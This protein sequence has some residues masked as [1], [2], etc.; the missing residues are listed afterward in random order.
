MWNSVVCGGRRG[1]KV[2]NDDAKTTGSRVTGSHP[3]QRISPWFIVW[4]LVKTK[5]TSLLHKFHPNMGWELQALQLIIPSLSESELLLIRYVPLLHRG[6]ILLIISFSK[7][8]EMKKTANITHTDLP[9]GPHTA[10][11]VEHTLVFPLWTDYL[12][13]PSCGLF[14]LFPPSFP[15]LLSSHRNRH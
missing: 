2:G 15:P 4:A 9:C 8:Q 10:A 12:L 7:S 6:N 14:S 11:S 5:L 13:C 3:G 1:Q